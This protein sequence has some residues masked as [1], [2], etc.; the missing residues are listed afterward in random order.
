M[1][2]RSAR[3][4]GDNHVSGIGGSLARLAAK[5]QNRK[6]K[7]RRLADRRLAGEKG[8]HGDPGRARRYA[9]HC[10]MRSKTSSTSPRFF[11]NMANS[12]KISTPAMM[13]VAYQIQ[14]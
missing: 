4:T 8:S 6:S 1:Y 7:I 9:S 10:L 2:A 14:V 11:S 13:P 5:I 3:R 12:A